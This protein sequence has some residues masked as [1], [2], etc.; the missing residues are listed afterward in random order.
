MT[1]RNTTPSEPSFGLA[2]GTFLV[3]VGVIG[4][5]LFVLK[6]S[7][8]SLMLICLIIAAGSAWSLYKGGFAPI[9]EAMN[10]GIT[11][12]FSAIYIFILIGVLIAAYIQ[13]G[14]VAALI[15]YGLEFILPTV[16]LPAGLILCSFMSVATGTS[17]GTVGTA[18]VVLIGVGSAMNI[19]LPVVAG[20]VVSG[21][22]F[23]DKMSPISDT[24]NLAAMSA[25]TD[26]YSH[27][28]SMLFTTGPA[29]LIALGVY[30]Y[31]GLSYSDNAMPEETIQTMLNAIDQT[32]SINL[33]CLLPLLVLLGLSFKRVSAEPAMMISA[34][35]ALLIAVMMQGK[36]CDAA[37]SAL[38]SGDKP[39]TGVASLDSLLSR[40]GISSMG[41][42][43]FLSLQALALGG[44]LA[45]FGFLRVLIAGIVGG[46]K[47]RASLVA[48]T[49][50]S[51][52]VGNMSMG[53]AYMSIILGGQLYGHAYDDKDIDRSVLSRS[54]EE[55]ATLSTPLIPWTTGGAFFAATLN[56]PTLDYLPYA[57]VN[58]I[59]PIIAILFAYLGVALFRAKKAHANGA[60]EP[61]ART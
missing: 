23:G 49:I 15:Y 31:L 12:A 58:L 41:W 13:S 1:Q 34:V 19:P 44:I 10:A 17:W 40:G 54:L 39:Q 3:I 4:I 37:L 14:T 18:G 20:M 36:E 61:S 16:F 25:K 45:E 24:T 59:N 52:V 47:R 57:F 29:Y 2:L 8:H 30:T 60:A 33:I 43:L 11:R 7:L 38:W 22:V 6:V 26:L 48:A 5:G 9:R 35:V 55:G 32:F 46:V 50:I 28:K 21:A 27:I 56:V 51:C 42:T 53:E